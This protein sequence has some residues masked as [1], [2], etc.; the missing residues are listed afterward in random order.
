MELGEEYWYSLSTYI[1]E[2]SAEKQSQYAICSK[3]NFPDTVQF[4]RNGKNSFKIRE[5]NEGA[6][7]WFKFEIRWRIRFVVTF[8]VRVVSVRISLK[9]YT[10]SLD[11]FH[12]TRNVWSFYKLF[13][14]L[15]LCQS[16]FSN[17]NIQQTSVVHFFPIVFM[18]SL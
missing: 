5:Y 4:K 16:K 2:K 1:W 6:F 18:L 7:L 14:V 15:S 17:L 11:L 12:L 9:I 10:L 3:G 8:A 13:D